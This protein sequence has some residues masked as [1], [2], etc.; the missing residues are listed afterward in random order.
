M[1]LL[2][3]YGTIIRLEAA[4]GRLTH[5]R[6]IPARDLAVDFI[7]ALPPE[8]LTAPLAG[9]N[10][11]TL[12]PGQTP[13]TA[14]L[15]RRGLHLSIDHAPYPAFTAER[16]GKPE[17]LLVL[18]DEEVAL[19]RDLLTHGWV[20]SDTGAAILPTD[21]Q[22]APGPVLTLG[23]LCLKL[24]AHDVL[25]GPNPDTLSLPAGPG[26]V[27]LTRLPDSRVPTREIPLRSQG[28]ASTPD[29]ADEAAFATQPNARLT[30]PA[31]AEFAIP[32]ILG[33]LADRDFLYRRGWSGLPPA[34]GRLH[35]QSQAVRAQDAYVLLER[36]VEGMI[37]NE[38]GVL[39]EAGHS[40][41][42]GGAH[43]R[44][45]G[46]EGEQYFIDHALLDT[47]PYLAGPH[48]VFYGGGYDN[49][50]HWLIDSL[51]PLSLLAPYL[52]PETT[53]LLP[54]SLAHFRAHP[55]GKL[56]HL[57]AL[58]AFGFG[59]MKRREMPGQ[60][61]QVEAL[62][63]PDRCTISQLPA[64]VLRAARDRVLSRRPPAPGP[65]TRIY[66][67]RA[68]TRAVANRHVVESV[69]T[70]HGFSPVLMEDLTALEQIDLFA[71]AEMVVAVHGAALANLIFCPPGTQV[72]ELCPD[73]EYRPF[74]NEISSK[75]G[76]THAVLPCA[77][78]DG[79]FNGRMTVSGARLNTL[80][81]LL[82]S[83]VAA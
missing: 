36:G 45:F 5:A 8:G 59:E 51:V 55:I 29:V 41:N 68:T 37:L 31:P 44:H 14:H 80:L 10:E 69:V 42:L 70:R 72:V 76:L 49:Y 77:T 47:A 50:Y 16:A 66:I 19:L 4:T 83:R 58:D 52:P 62:F 74:F 27:T 64:V 53:L 57:E 67:R 82:M 65:R 38:N 79:T 24:T 33:S 60:I 61:C 63:W 20:R 13:G 46:R 43:P 11:I 2:T 6:L 26:R 78:D 12:I 71:R 28:S 34:R 7:L 75:L 17:T 40:G 32:P 54:A 9:P 15:Q 23:R 81:G 56:D 1:R 30:I 3:W 39:N 22:I 48:A 18:P 73:C 35:L 21:M 25:P